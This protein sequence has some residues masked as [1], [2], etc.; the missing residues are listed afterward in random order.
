[1]DSTTKFNCEK[2]GNIYNT[3]QA[4][5][6]HMTKAHV[7]EKLRSEDSQIESQMVL[8]LSLEG[9]VKDFS[10]PPPLSPPPPTPPHSFVPPLLQPTPPAPSTFVHKEKCQYPDC[11]NTAINFFK[12]VKLNHYE[13]VGHSMGFS[14]KSHSNIFLC[15]C[16]IKH[17][18]LRDLRKNPPLKV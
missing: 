4:L 12:S 14:L 16:C 1:M 8:E 18:P 11:S 3:K 6:T 9:R 7:A 17:V 15:D 5:R 10:P 13:K 2:C